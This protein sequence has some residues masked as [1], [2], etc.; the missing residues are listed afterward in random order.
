MFRSFLKVVNQWE[1]C[2]EELH[3]HRADDSPAS[4]VISIV[5]HIV[6]SAVLYVETHF[7]PSYWTH[8]GALVADNPHSDVR[9]P[10]ADERR[11][12][13]STVE[14]GHAWIRV[15]QESARCGCRPQL[16]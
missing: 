2:G 15:R 3:Y 5:G 14:I 10:A 12:R 13:R 8:F 16:S 11:H 4:I 6:V 9:T 7:A 1:A